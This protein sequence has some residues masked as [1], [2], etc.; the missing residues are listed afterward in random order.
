MKDPNAVA[1]GRKGGEAGT[2]KAKARDPEK[3]RLA[4]LKGAEARWGK[5]AKTIPQGKSHN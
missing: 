2:G 1:L 3:M 4:G 5:K